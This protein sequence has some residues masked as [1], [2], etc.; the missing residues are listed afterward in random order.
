MRTDISAIWLVFLQVIRLKIIF[1][2]KEKTSVFL[3]LLVLHEKLIKHFN[4]SNNEN[5]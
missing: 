1:N 3:F 4:Q 2:F 5:I